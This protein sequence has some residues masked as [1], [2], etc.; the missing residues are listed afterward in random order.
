MQDDIKK[1]CDI[2]R[3]GG[4][5]LYPTDT[6]WGIG[7]DAT[8]EEAV[9]RIYDL[10]QRDDTK[11]MLVLMD[12]PAKLQTYVKEVPDIAWDLIDL[13]DKP[14]TIIYDGAKNLAPN[15]IAPDG[16]IGIRITAETF[17]MEL[18]RQFRKPI[19]STSANIS[20]DPSPSSFSEIGQTIKEGVD[21]IVTYRQKEQTKAKPS[22][23]VKLGKDGSIKIIR[24]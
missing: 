23:I 20:G 9:K 7:C 6:I 2:L 11:S 1:A 16:S 14:L 17:S 12:N 8:N 4:I 21:Y 3:K 22:G 10:K 18:C 19:V 5:I 15:L 13:A 24:K